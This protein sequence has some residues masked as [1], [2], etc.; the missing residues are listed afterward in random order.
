MALDAICI[1]ALTP[2]LRTTLVGAKIDKVQQ[3]ARDMLILSVHSRNG[4]S[5]RLLASCGTGTARLHITQESF[6]N[7]Q[8]PPMFCMLLRKHLVGA[9]IENIYQ[10]DFE[11]M[12]IFDL[13]AFDEMGTPVK[14]QL[15]LE[16]MGRNSNIIL[17][18]P[19]GHI[20]DCLR[21]VDSDMSISRQVLP[22]LIYRLPPKQEKPILSFMTEDEIR[23]C[24]SVKNNEKCADKWLLDSF[25][26]LSPLI[27]REISYRACGEVSKPL[28]EF[29]AEQEEKLLTELFVLRSL[30]NTEA[31]SA[32][33]LVKDEL[34]HDF[35]FMPIL[36]YENAMKI[37]AFSDFSTLLDSF[38]TLR[39]QRE[40][41][42]RKAQG[43]QK[44]V[45]S[46]HERA[47]RKLT[48]RREELLRAENREIHRKR[49]DLVTANLYR[50]K[51]GDHVLE[52]EDYYED[53]TPQ[54]KI[55]LD[56]LKTP[57]QN[58]AKF[59]RDYNKAKT[60]ETY[61][62]D[63]IA[64]GE[65]EANYLASVLDAVSRT[66]NERDLAEIRRELT[67]T[68]FLRAQKNAKKEK[69][70]QNAPMRFISTSGMEILVG[71]NNT[72]NDLLTTK[73]ARRTDIWLHVQKL[74]GSH[75]IISCK[76]SAPDKQAL[77]EA[78]SLAAYFSQGRDIGKLPVDY[79]QV[80]Y[81][82]KPSGSMPGAVIYTDYKTII[83][84]P[85]EKLADQLKA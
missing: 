27:C 39:D 58:A 18:G 29:S 78:A 66:E 85:D 71:K 50:M 13:N 73:Q 12:L 20:I 74:H 61:L 9:H 79:T 38:F 41:Q 56:P 80:R 82:K 36:Q 43:L 7:P 30:I 67:E 47:L 25:S 60:A 75:V 51:K 59:Y 2:E 84:T 16:M 23:V 48:A 11:R 34:Q 83:A 3:P 21:R 52:C 10:P 4:G 77:S 49:G 32:S 22:G 69:I 19:E 1:A 40:M 15:V 81:V 42:R 54:I 64:K 44:S 26:A 28:A 14:K 8:S 62:Y 46:A 6:E 53:S 45:K 65:R 5:A 35:S 68:G 17:V 57:Q 72:Q 31:F 63:L 33:M 70:K 24:F 55:P 76:D 37:Q